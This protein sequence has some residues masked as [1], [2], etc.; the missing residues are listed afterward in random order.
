MPFLKA[1][2]EEN[3]KRYKI[4]DKLFPK[5]DHDVKTKLSEI[6]KVPE[7]RKRVKQFLNIVVDTIDVDTLWELLKETANA[8][9]VKKM[10]ADLANPN[11]G[12]TY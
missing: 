5:Y 11:Q 3:V 8:F 12:I 7:R 1:V 6:K 2:F 4:V 10:K 9:T